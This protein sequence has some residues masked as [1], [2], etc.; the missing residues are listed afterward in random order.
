MYHEIIILFAQ[1]NN[2]DC[3]FFLKTSLNLIPI[4]N[5]IIDLWWLFYNVHQTFTVTVSNAYLFLF[6]LPVLVL[7]LLVLITRLIVSETDV[8]LSN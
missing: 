2:N 1:V 4:V 6:H 5:G 7:A 3:N 8:V